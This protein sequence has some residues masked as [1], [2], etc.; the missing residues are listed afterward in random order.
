MLRAGLL[1]VGASG[2]SPCSAPR[3]HPPLLAIVC[4]V[5]RRGGSSRPG[6]SRR[7]AVHVSR[8]GFTV[9]H[10]AS[11][12]SLQRVQHWALTLWA[13][14]T[15][16]SEK[17]TRETCLNLAVVVV[18]VIV[19]VVV[20]VAVVSCYVFVC[21]CVCEYVW[22]CVFV[23]RLCVGCVLLVVGCWLLV[24]GG[25]WLLLFL[26]CCCFCFTPSS[27]NTRTCGWQLSTS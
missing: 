22:L 10:A 8:T 18:V 6:A 3:T 27:I 4:P 17:R 21:F 23:C 24:V 1:G 16:D 5:G 20:V 15:G 25:C 2:T 7:L 26:C 12:R 9:P 14:Q 13:Q 11:L 19:V